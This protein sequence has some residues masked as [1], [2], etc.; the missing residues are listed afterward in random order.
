[1]QDHGRARG[2]PPL[3][4]RR[5]PATRARLGV[6]DESGTRLRRGRG[7]PPKL[8]NERRGDRRSTFG[9][10][11]GSWPSPS[12]AAARGRRGRRVVICF[13]GDDSGGV[14]DRTES[15]AGILVL[16][17]RCSGLGIR[18]LDV[19]DDEFRRHDRPAH[20]PRGVLAKQGIEIPLERV[21]T[22]FFNQAIFERMLGAGDLTIESGGETG[23][24]EVHR[25]PQALDRAERDL[26]PDGGRTRTASSTASTP[27]SIASSRRRPRHRAATPS[28]PSRSSSSTS[29][30][31]AGR[32]SPRPSSTPKK[33]ELLAGCECGVP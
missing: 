4:H 26:P 32:A 19:G 28:V 7:V 25:H 13:F 1:M 11:G 22:V 16:V 15:I 6:A 24:A 31:P 17:G 8:L 20:L 27:A 14:L 5:P 12:L 23:T 18:Y 10:T 9:R 21:N 33:A 3:R 29:C 2:R 30:E